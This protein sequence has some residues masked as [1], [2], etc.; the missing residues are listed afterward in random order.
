MSYNNRPF[1]QVDRNFRVDADSWS[2]EAF[3]GEYDGN[4]NLIYKAVAV[5]GANE[6]DEV[7]QIAKLVYDANDNLLRVEWPLNQYG[8]CSTEYNFSW[9]DR[10]TYT[11]S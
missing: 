4:D 6:G 5:A 2:D 11:Y 10:A 3:R 1:G 8:R 9:T 7:W